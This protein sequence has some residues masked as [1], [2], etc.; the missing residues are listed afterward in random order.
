MK[1]QLKKDKEF[2]S[3]RLFD[4]SFIR[5]YGNAPSPMEINEKVREMLEEA[6][7][8][9]GVE[10]LYVNRESVDENIINLLSDANLERINALKYQNTKVKILERLLKQVINGYKQVN[11]IQSMKF[12]ERLEKLIERY[13]SRHSDSELEEIIEDMRQLADEI[14]EDYN[15]FKKLGI[16]FEEKAF[17]DVLRE[18]KSARELMKDETLK[19]IASEILDI[20]K[21]NT[22]YVD[23]HKREDIKA[24]MRMNILELLDKYDY[25]PDAKEDSIKNVIEQVENFKNYN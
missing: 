5:W 1:L 16:S 7:K 4:L 12:S 9:Q 8:S 25:P 11:K 20:V 23:W 14:I 18:S 15:S 21:N 24:E 13:S 6:I 3:I 17:Y 22:K 10:Q 19:Q 2:I